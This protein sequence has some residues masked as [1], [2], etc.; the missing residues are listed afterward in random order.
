MTTTR[1]TY[2]LT[3]NAPSKKGLQLWTGKSLHALRFCSDKH[4][5][6]VLLDIR[7][8]L[9]SVNLHMPAASSYSFNRS[10]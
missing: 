2:V 8:D 10:R 5:G 4:M 7:K 6:Q 9:D 1:R 3:L